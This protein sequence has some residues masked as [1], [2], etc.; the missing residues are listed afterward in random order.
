MHFFGDRLKYSWHQKDVNICEAANL[1][2]SDVFVS[3]EETLAQQVRDYVEKGSS[4]E[5]ELSRSGQ[6]HRHV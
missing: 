5:L 4:Q 1:P 3:K 2:A 6:V